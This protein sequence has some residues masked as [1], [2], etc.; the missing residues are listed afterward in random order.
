MCAWDQLVERTLGICGLVIGGPYFARYVV[1]SDDPKHWSVG[2][3][4]Y[5]KPYELGQ[6]FT[7]KG[8]ECEIFRVSENPAGET[9][10]DLRPCE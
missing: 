10:I 6:K 4:Q 3:I 5:G 8:F 1:V 9:L 2:S 7:V